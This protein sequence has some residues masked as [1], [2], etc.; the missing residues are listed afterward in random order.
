MVVA[1]KIL[2]AANT[3]PISPFRPNAA[4]GCY[5][6][7]GAGVSATQSP[8]AKAIRIRTL[9]HVTDC[10]SATL[11][12]AKTSNRVARG[13][14]K[15]GGRTAPAAFT[16]HAKANGETMSQIPSIIGVAIFF[17]ICYVMSTVNLT[18]MQLGLAIT[19]LVVVY[20]MTAFWYISTNR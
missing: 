14:P 4:S 17:G 12:P 20:S 15:S 18:G 6:L 5:T 2:T 10:N 7:T 11:R 19:S 3:K 9:G 1:R 13:M 16:R 8:S